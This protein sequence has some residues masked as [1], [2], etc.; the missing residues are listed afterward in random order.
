MSAAEALK[1]ARAAG[2]E[3]GLDGDDLVLEAAVAAASRRARPACRATR[4]GSCALLRPASDGWSAEDWQAFFD[5]RAG[6]A[7]HDGGLSRQEAEALAFDHCVVEW[8]M[9]HPVRSNPVACLG[10][11]RGGEQAGVV[12]P[13]GTETG[14]HAWLHSACWPAW[15]SGR[16]AEAVAALSAMGIG[17]RRPMKDNDVKF[18]KES[19]A[20]GSIE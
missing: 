15:Y 5:E 1:A 8:L 9:R 16:K 4:P 14:G 17:S 2:I 20:K 3:L 6:I 7:E 18:R 11:G 10:C 12:L 19:T 13:F